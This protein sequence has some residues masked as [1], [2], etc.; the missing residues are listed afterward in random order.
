MAEKR[1]STRDT[2]K[3]AGRTATTRAEDTD[4]ADAELGP[5]DLGPPADAKKTDD[6]YIYPDSGSF[7][8][9]AHKGTQ[10]ESTEKPAQHPAGRR[11]S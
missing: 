9:E 6:G 10:A 11:R 1:K 2:D 3:P 4:D 7:V 5:S 8:V